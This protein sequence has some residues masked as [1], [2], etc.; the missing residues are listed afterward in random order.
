MVKAHI[1]CSP[2][3]LKT[4][5]VGLRAAASCPFFELV[6]P[7]LCLG[8]HSTFLSQLFGFE[9][10]VATKGS[11]ETV[12]SASSCR[13][14]GS[15]WVTQCLVSHS[16]NH[17]Y[18]RNL[19]RFFYQIKSLLLSHHHGTCALVSEVVYEVGYE[20]LLRILQQKYL[21]SRMYI[22]LLLLKL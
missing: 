11:V 20:T 5:T 21:F 19:R 17:G 9:Q 6:R 10:C 12:P 3:F 14:S 18:I 22:L 2:F 15:P 1:K 4:C 16:G 8:P 7:G 13:A